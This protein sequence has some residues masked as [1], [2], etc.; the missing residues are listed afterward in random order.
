MDGLG[1]DTTNILGI[2]A[3]QPA[4]KTSGT[5]QLTNSRYQQ[6]SV[7]IR[8]EISPGR[9]TRTVQDPS[10][11]RFS[12]REGPN[13]LPSTTTTRKTITK[14]G[15]DFHPD[16]SN[17]FFSNAKILNPQSIKLV[18]SRA[19][20]ARLQATSRAGAQLSPSTAVQAISARLTC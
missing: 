15:S 11:D 10:N 4:S 5:I 8:S 7:G 1:T 19:I 2:S 13:Y 20:M 18:P 9:V 14:R 16:L 17:K 3:P 6:P 12:V